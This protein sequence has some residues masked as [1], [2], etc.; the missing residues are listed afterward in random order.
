MTNRWKDLCEA[1]RA[2]HTKV[3]RDSFIA[4]EIANHIGAEFAKYIAAPDSR[5][6]RFYRFTHPNDH[7]SYT[8]VQSG[9][10]AVDQTPSNQ[11][12]FGLGVIIGYDRAPE[13]DFRWPLYITLSD[14]IIIE[15]SISNKKL[16]LIRRGVDYD[17]EAI[18]AKMYD[19]MVASRTNGNQVFV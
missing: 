3:Q 8:E 2:F 9:S 11:W 6:V 16:E 5:R 10:N 15:N 4:G 19:A 18:C 7:C 13:F 1:L 14:P 17:Y 12:K